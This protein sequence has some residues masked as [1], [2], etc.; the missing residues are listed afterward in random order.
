MVG[1]NV[2]VIWNKWSNMT[3]IVLVVLNIWI[4]LIIA[5]VP[6]A[7]SFLLHQQIKFLDTRT[8]AL[9]KV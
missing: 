3:R 8:T 2:I 4:E 9:L 1:F 6:Y 7:T 5:C